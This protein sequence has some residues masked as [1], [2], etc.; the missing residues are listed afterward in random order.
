AGGQSHLFAP[1]AA[2]MLRF[3]GQHEMVHATDGGLRIADAGRDARTQ[4]RGDRLSRMRHGDVE[5]ARLH[6]RGPAAHRI[7]EGT[8]RGVRTTSRGRACVQHA[9]L[10]RYTVLP[11]SVQSLDTLKR[12]SE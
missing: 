2:S 4:Y 1:V 7:V 6:L 8:G 5:L 12:P 11:I 3:L 10:R 9:P